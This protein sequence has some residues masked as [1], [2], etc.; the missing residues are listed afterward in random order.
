MLAAT[1]ILLCEAAPI[2]RDLI[3][4]QKGKATS[5]KGS[6]RES[7]KPDQPKEKTSAIVEQKQITSDSRLKDFLLQFILMYKF[8]F[9]QIPRR[10]KSIKYFQVW[11]SI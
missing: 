11:L 2:E 10:T 3:R 4:Q 5:A 9:H 6:S 1:Y 8:I 7:K